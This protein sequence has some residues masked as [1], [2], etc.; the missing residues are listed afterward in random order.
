MTKDEKQ[1]PFC[2]ETINKSAIKCRFCQS[3]IELTT[4][5]EKTKKTINE[6]PSLGSFMDPRF[7]DYPSNQASRF[8]MY[9]VILSAFIFSFKIWYGLSEEF[10]ML[11]KILLGLVGGFIATG[12]SEKVY[13]LSRNESRT[14]RRIVCVLGG[15]LGITTSFIVFTVVNKLILE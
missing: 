12:V 4:E 6:I 8:L 3:D 11:V 15:C 14:Y 9:A 5:S 1:C 2:A 7:S 13:S 10:D